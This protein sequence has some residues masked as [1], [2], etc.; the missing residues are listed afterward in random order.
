[1]GWIDSNGT[2]VTSAF[3]GVT[4]PL[5]ELYDE[6]HQRGWDVDKVD[7][8]GDG[9][10]EATVKNPYGETISKVGPDPNTAVGH[11]LVGLMRQETM[12]YPRTAAWTATWENERPEI[13]QAYAEAPTY[14]PKA[15]GAWKELGE[16]SVRRAEAI[17][18]QIRVEFTHDPYP[19]KDVNEMADDIR[20]N[21]H[22][23]VSKHGLSHPLWSSDQALAY[24]LVH[25]VLGHAAVGGD[26]GWHGE[27]GATSA[28]MPLL[29][30][31]A[32]KALFT[33]AIG[34]AAHNSYYRQM[35]PQ[36]IAF[37][38][39]YLT[40]VQEQENAAGHPGV[41]PSQ[42]LVPSGIPSIES[43]TAG[44]TQ[45][46]LRQLADHLENEYGK[47]T[48]KI[49]YQFP[50]GWSI[51]SPARVGDVYREGELMG[52][53]LGEQEFG[54][55]WE[56]FDN[57]EPSR[58]WKSLR[59]PDNIP[60]AT[61]GYSGGQALGRHNGPVHPKYQPY[62]DEYGVDYETPEERAAEEAWERVGVVQRI[63]PNDGWESG[64]EPL[65]DNAYLWQKEES[66]LDPLDHNGIRDQAYKLDR[67][68]FG[69]QDHN[70]MPDLESQRQAVANAFRSVLLEPRQTPRWAATHYQHLLHVPPGV[71][72]PIRYSDALEGQREAHNQARGLPEG[73][74]SP[75]GIN[76]LQNW[77]KGLNPKL[78][79]AEVSELARR[80][81]FHMIAEEEAQVTADD[82]GGQLL[83]MQIS[84]ATN[85][86][87]KRRLDVLT[88]P[89][90]DQKFDFGK[91]RLFHK[92]FN[93]P[94]PGVY[95]DFLYSHIR[96]IAGVGLHID[97]F[98]RAAREDVAN[99]G[100]KGHHFRAKVSDLIP[101]VGP[102]EI[103]HAW[104]RLQ[105]HT[106][107]L[108]IIGP[109]VAEALGYK[110]D[111]E[112]SPRDYFKLE[113]QL[114]A[115]RDAAG[116]SHVPL[117]QFSNGMFDN[118]NYGHGVHRDPSPFAV[119]NPTPYDQVDWTQY[120][121]LSTEKWKD[122]YWWKSTEPNRD[123]VGKD[124]DQIVATQH[125]A[126]EIPFRTA[127][128]VKPYYHVAMPEAEESIQQHGLDNTLFTGDLW[129][130]V[131]D[132]DDGAYLW[133]SLDKAQEYA[134][135]LHP[136][137]KP[138]HI[139]EVDPTGLEISPDTT[140]VDPVEGAWYAPHVP[141]EN[142]RRIARIDSVPG[143]Y[144]TQPADLTNGQWELPQSAK[145]VIAT[146]FF[147]H[148]ES[149]ELVDGE[150]GQSIMQHTRNALGLS[151]EQVW[152][153]DPEVGKR[154]SLPS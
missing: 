66:G 79:D 88:K 89:N 34:Q 126:Q 147:V 77:I 123:E 23:T 1:M 56:D 137:G 92:S 30:P 36:K 26:W 111:K 104:Y 70:G 54:D 71:S 53:C 78:D 41:H 83:P 128:S 112:V 80:E 45:T 22:V 119:L 82:P 11:C 100:G 107:Q 59:D 152:A 74:A 101:G 136:E 12:R 64:I 150:P 116:Y 35:A 2:D 61:W 115:G 38:D 131:D 91:E 145:G 67:G 138:M 153:M 51:R 142:L 121:N 90:V 99:H 55:N 113:R 15:A 57:P 75:E 13:A 63:D 68:W 125:P 98:A 18:N 39:D 103:S 151:T 5:R 117:G 106:S 102:K 65:P 93:A 141:P 60:H 4:T 96:P 69:L 21:K 3:Q 114:A 109:S 127:S 73:I 124:W 87:I 86:A 110:R 62:L 33:E 146:P 17:A 85:K 97:D 31:N 95:G 20:N 149:G 72:D 143:Q 154:N 52:N 28:H 40:K 120:P 16:D 130:N 44:M 9:L 108:A 58:Y 42:S 19:Y 135:G 7:V 81:L 76:A 8:N 24:R 50:D 43:K 139:Y 14:D 134:Q 84:D 118:F 105:P 48:S 140:G 49:L 10:Y 27:N 46:Q 6:I 32:Q 148:P 37:L 47:D 133:D 132:W 29:S 144:F 122:P 25:D 94:D 129:S